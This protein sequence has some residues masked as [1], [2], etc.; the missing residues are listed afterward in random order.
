M[1]PLMIFKP[2][3]VSPR[4]KKTQWT[5]PNPDL[6]NMIIPFTVFHW[7]YN[8]FLN[9]DNYICM[10][11]VKVREKRHNVEV[12]LRYSH[13][14]WL[15]CLVSLISAAMIHTFFIFSFSFLLCLSLPHLLCDWCDAPGG[16]AG[17]GQERGLDYTLPLRPADVVALSSDCLRDSSSFSPERGRQVSRLLLQSLLLD[18]S[19]WPRF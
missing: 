15:I 2:Q 16:G 17:G 11:P 14:R 10:I 7:F 3:S 9:M 19:R 18:D 8:L 1:G 13:Q 6:S 5:N 12:F 4:L